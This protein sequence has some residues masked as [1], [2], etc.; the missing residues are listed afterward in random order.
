MAV[1]T[2]GIVPPMRAAIGLTEFR[3]QPLMLEQLEGSLED[4]MEWW[5]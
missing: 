4:L 5:P 2:L 1:I 3:S